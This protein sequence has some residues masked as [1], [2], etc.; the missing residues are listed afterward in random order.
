MRYKIT[1]SGNGAFWT[2]TRL[3]DCASVT[4]QGDDAVT[5]SELLDATTESYTDDDLAAE[6]DSV[7]TTDRLDD[8]L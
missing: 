2:I 1:S 7:L 6:Y 3:A 5:F 8:R 4:L